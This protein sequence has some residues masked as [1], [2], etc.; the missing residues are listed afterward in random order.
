[1]TK[2]QS[3]IKSFNNDFTDKYVIKEVADQSTKNPKVSTATGV[4]MKKLGSES[5]RTK[6]VTGF[7]YTYY[8]WAYHK[9]PYVKSARISSDPVQT[10][11]LERIQDSLLYT[12][13]SNT[14]YEVGEVVIIDKKSGHIE[15]L[16]TTN[17]IVDTDSLPMETSDI[18][19]IKLEV[20]SETVYYDENKN[21][22]QPEDIIGQSS[23]DDTIGIQQPLVESYETK[24]VYSISSSV[25]CSDSWV[26]TVRESI[27]KQEVIDNNK[28][29][30]EAYTGYRGG[31]KFP[32]PV[33]ARKLKHGLH[34]GVLF[35]NDSNKEDLILP[36]AM[37]KDLFS[38]AAKY[39]K[40]TGK[41][42][43]VNSIFRT[44]DKQ[45][46][47]YRKMKVDEQG[48][49]GAV[50]TA[51]VG[52]SKHQNGT[53]VDFQIA[54]G[55]NGY[56]SVKDFKWSDLHDEAKKNPKVFDFLVEH[57]AKYNFIHPEWAKSKKD[58]EGWHWE[59][60]GK[61]K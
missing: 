16:G 42:L 44:Q 36:I 29:D 55:D 23:P 43:L 58:F 52:T 47:L 50:P 39:E 13:K 30:I 51:E 61:S 15:I 5:D 46:E 4:I 45:A 31:P 19:D 20:I 59:Y 32:F 35:S 40:K 26:E 34:N 27:L 18:C 33:L 41:P 25:N 37:E 9:L 48:K 12:T 54:T 8:I 1:M 60:I 49:R 2:P 24:E 38:L 17:E 57:G 3:P 21:I 22:I 56:N 14:S 28:N 10:P 7:I 11:H 6:Q 53:A